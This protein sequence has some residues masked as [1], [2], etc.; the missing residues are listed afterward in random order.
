MNTV[1]NAISQG[2]N[3]VIGMGTSLLV[4]FLAIAVL[5]P[6]FIIP[7]I[8][9]AVI[10]AI[11]GQI[12]TGA[13]LPVKREMSNTRSPVFSHFNAAIAGLTSIRAYGAEQQFIAEARLRS[14]LWMRP[15]RVVYNLNRYALFSSLY[16]QDVELTGNSDGLQ[17]VLTY[18]AVFSLLVLR[19][20]PDNMTY[21]LL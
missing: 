15:A 18:W 2:L 1:D 8:G 9:F 16:P 13:Q 3:N 10:G 4:N 17:F 14:D 5:T 21:G 7:G 11:V 20:K 12:Y 6:F 19:G